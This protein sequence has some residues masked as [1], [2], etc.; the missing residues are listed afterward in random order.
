MSA[1]PSKETI[2]EREL[3]DIKRDRAKLKDL[4][5]SAYDAGLELQK[6]P[7]ALRLGTLNK[8]VAELKASIAAREQSVIERLQQKNLVRKIVGK[9][10]ALI[11]TVEGQCRPKWKEAF[12]ALAERMKLNP[13]SEEKRVREATEVPKEYRLVI[14]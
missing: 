14:E 10:I 3:A 8:E 7:A 6:T 9:F 13:Q 5:T 1:K 11:Q 4:V 12:L 2:T